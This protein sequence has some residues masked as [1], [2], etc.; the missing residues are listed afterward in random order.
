[1][2]IDR[3]RRRKRET[4]NGNNKV[5]KGKGEKQGLG[6]IPRRTVCGGEK[7]GEVKVTWGG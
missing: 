4:E 6:S 7:T 2:G 1:M 3:G 5:K